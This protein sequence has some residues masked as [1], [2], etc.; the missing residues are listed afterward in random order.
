MGKLAVLVGGDDGL[1]LIVIV[2]ILSA[3][4]SSIC[5]VQLGV[6]PP[7]NDLFLIV[8]CCSGP[9]SVTCG[10][11]TPLF[12]RSFDGAGWLKAH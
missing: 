5:H 10:L 6:D 2:V 1:V 7:H 11:G 9:A 3:R 8:L 4:S 12:W